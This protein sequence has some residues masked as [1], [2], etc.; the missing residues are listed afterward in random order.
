MPEAS[1]RIAGLSEDRRRLLERLL[2][3]NGTAGGRGR[4]AAGAIPPAVTPSTPL[5]GKET[6]EQSSTS[7][8]VKANYKRFYDAINSQLDASVFGQFSFFLNYGYLPNLNPQH[9]RI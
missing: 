3:Q 6:F 2:K 4:A 1:H 5:P 9:S 7:G 8:E